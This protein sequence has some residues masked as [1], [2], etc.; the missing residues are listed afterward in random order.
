MFYT[1]RYIFRL[2]F[3]HFLPILVYISTIDGLESQTRLSA[4]VALER[5]I[6]EGTE[7]TLTCSGDSSNGSGVLR[8]L[9]RRSGGAGIDGFED[10][11]NFATRIVQVNANRPDIAANFVVSRK[12]DGAMFICGDVETL[13]F[14]SQTPTSTV[15]IRVQFDPRSL[16]LKSLPEGGM[17]EDMSK[18][19]I[20][21]TDEG[22][23]NPPVNIT[24]RHLSPLGGVENLGEE[25]QVSSAQRK[26]GS[27]GGSGTVT[28]SNLTILA[29]RRLNGHRI[30]C[31]VEKPGRI[32]IFRQSETLEV[33]FA[34]NNVQIHP[35]VTGGISE[36]EV[37]SLTCAVAVSHPPATVRW[38]E[39]PPESG[40]DFDSGREISDLAQ[41]DMTPGEYGGMLVDSTLR[42]SKTFRSNSQTEYQCVVS[43][44]ALKSPVVAKYKLNVLYPP[45]IEIVGLPNDPNEGQSVTLSCLSHGGMP[46]KGFAFSWWHG[47]NI[48]FPPSAD[49][50][51][52][53]STQ[54]ELSQVLAKS[55]VASLNASVLANIFT[56]YMTALPGHTG[57]HLMLDNVGIEQGG[58][59]GCQIVNGGGTA[60]S[61]Y[62][63]LINY[64]PRIHPS[65]KFIQYAQPG[66]KAEFVLTVEAR[67]ATAEFIWF[68]IGDDTG[69]SNK[70][71]NIIITQSSSQTRQRNRRSIAPLKAI[72]T[73]VSPWINRVKQTSS[74]SGDNRMKFTLAFR[75]VTEADFGI[76]MCQ[77]NHKAG[78][79]EFY[80]ELKRQSDAKGINPDTIRIASEG[81]KIRVE[82]E[83][84]NS[85][86]YSQI[87]F[88]ICLSSSTSSNSISG[89]GRNVRPS[90]ELVFLK[91]I[92]DSASSSLISSSTGTTST[93]GNE[94]C[95]DY[96][97]TF[98]ELGFLQLELDRPLPEYTFQFLVYQDGQLRQITR[99]VRW[100]GD[101]RFQA[102]A[103]S[104]LL[105]HII[106]GIL[107]TLLIVCLTAF[108]IYYF[109]TCLK[110]K[111]MKKLAPA[112]SNGLLH[113]T[114]TYQTLDSGKTFGSP[115]SGPGSISAD[116]G[117]LHPAYARQS[118]G[119]ASLQTGPL[120]TLSIASSINEDN[121]NR[122][123]PASSC[124]S[125]KGF[126][127]PQPPAHMV[128]S[129]HPLLG[130]AYNTMQN[131][132]MRG[133]PSNASHVSAL[134]QRI[135]SE[136]YIAAAKAASIAVSESIAS[137][138]LDAMN[139]TGGGTGNYRPNSHYAE[140]VSMIG[141]SISAL[142]GLGM[143]QGKILAD[144]FNITGSS[145][146]SIVYFSANANFFTRFVTR[147]NSGW[148]F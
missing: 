73:S 114:R 118:T 140:S 69:L 28:Q 10:L 142:D 24:W 103:S 139:Q 64:A 115:P 66:M 86:F 15:I 43:Q 92:K 110:R 11:A 105:V 44:A 47:K 38:F 57:R 36:G 12:D 85:Q 83:P 21:Q 9:R 121:E 101:N 23:A 112:T 52:P 133:S 40:G 135:L 131:S 51:G 27:I 3:L 70:A 108:L 97:I 111:S 87:V 14:Q 53:S 63:L 141:G 137:G 55:L 104:K 124:Q 75:E 48:Q 32:A 120:P 6:P 109:C 61:L 60:Q 145:F 72:S 25:M 148:Q 76:Y 16:S 74:I 49:L 126:Y 34:P 96:E 107:I 102:S 138:S 123:T 58:W 2:H 29:H 143:Y 26:S 144:L 50:K 33:I 81:K 89:S 116:I 79:R 98:A 68:W 80:F 132:D 125:A 77:V 95:A 19:I 8:I 42:V 136:V 119:S 13:G 4:N 5:P 147:G 90:G 62:L 56:T 128:N 7:V 99:Q 41:I 88:R 82:F 20:C 59:Y 54:Q 45:S 93:N 71:R 22:G 35:S 106:I 113:G 129:A 130:N 17:R 78:N 31:S 30:E 65:T 146:I 127:S 46:D 100:S 67:P 39:F 134:T 18:V 122:R 84:P 1:T 117:L 94:E 37:I 91:P